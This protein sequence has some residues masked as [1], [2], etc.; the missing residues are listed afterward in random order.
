MIPYLLLVGL[1]LGIVATWFAHR[2]EHRPAFWLVTMM[3]L[4]GIVLFVSS[5]AD[6]AIAVLGM[7]AFIALLRFAVVL[8]EASMQHEFHGT[9]RATL[10]SLPTL[11]NEVWGVGLAA[12]YGL[13]DH[14]ADDLAAIRSVAALVV[15]IGASLMVW[16]SYL[17]RR[18]ATQASRR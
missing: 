18:P 3:L 6:K 14:R 8:L 5:F 11:L 2:F 9:S 7:L 10:G 17:P 1:C 12:L 13:V 15:L 4:A 16:W